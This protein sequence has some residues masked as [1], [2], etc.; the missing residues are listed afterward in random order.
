M[1]VQAEVMGV[2]IMAEVVEEVEAEVVL[3]E[4]LRREAIHLLEG[5]ALIDLLECI[6]QA[7]DQEVHINQV[8]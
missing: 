8:R 6:Q 5:I 7:E 1:E 2:R 4:A 3:P